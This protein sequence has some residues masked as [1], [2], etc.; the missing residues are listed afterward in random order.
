MTRAQ[1]SNTLA[2]GSRLGAGPLQ[3]APRPARPDGT[4]VVARGATS[5][6]AARGLRG[7]GREAETEGKFYAQ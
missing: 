5:I 1:P 6:P 2:D 4:Q 3:R 7:N